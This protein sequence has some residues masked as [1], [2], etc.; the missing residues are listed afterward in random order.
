MTE[1]SLKEIL[2][3]FSFRYQAMPQSI[4]EMSPAELF[5]NQKLRSV[6]DL[7]NPLILNRVESAQNR[8]RVSHDKQVKSRISILGGTIYACRYMARHL[9]GLKFLQIRQGCSRSDAVDNLL[10][11]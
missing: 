1:G 6:F 8:Q 2:V 4:T 3:R 10:N 7:L 5:I 9:S 11:G